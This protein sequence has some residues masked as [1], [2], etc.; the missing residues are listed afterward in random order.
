MSSERERR[1]VK[2]EGATCRGASLKGSSEARG[3][4]S[5]RSRR[6]GEQSQGEIY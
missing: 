6:G 5:L 1:E 4:G 2:E 3:E